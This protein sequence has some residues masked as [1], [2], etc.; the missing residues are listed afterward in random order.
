MGRLEDIG[1]GIGNFFKDTGEFLFGTETAKQAANTTAAATKS[2]VNMADQ[3]AEQGRQYDQA[4]AQSMGANAADYMQ[5]ANLSAQQ[6]AAQQAGLAAKQGAREQ[7]KAMRSAG[8]NPAASAARAGQAAG[9]NYAGTYQQGQQAGVGQ[10]M[11]GANQFANQGAEM[12]GRQATGIGIQMGGAS[13]QAASAEQKA[14]NTA[15]TLSTA[16]TAAASFSDERVKEDIS[17]ADD[18]KI[19]RILAKID[20]VK[21]KYTNKAMGK[22]EQ[23][24]VTAQNLEAAG[25]GGAVEETPEGV[26][27][28]SGPKVENF[29]L[30]AI[31]MLADKVDKI[32]DHLG[33]GGAK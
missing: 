15:N 7:I 20:P 32:V 10:Y 26:K 16:L 11:Q 14:K 22:G 31:K 25:L 19:A 6:N 24:G 17:K 12:A 30:D 13:Q 18:D 33:I 28:V 4:T 8:M 2:A 29:N 3:A 9:R 23:V 27:I 21:Y 1:Q 5:K